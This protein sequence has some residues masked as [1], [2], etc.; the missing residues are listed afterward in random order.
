MRVHPTLAAAPILI[1]ALGAGCASSGPVHAP[2][3]ESAPAVSPRLAQLGRTMTGAF[4]SSA[5]AAADPEHFKDV[6]LVMT[7]IWPERT[8]GLWLYVEQALATDLANPYRQRVYHV[9]ERADGT[10]VSGVSTLAGDP[11]RF[12]DGSG[13]PF[14]FAAV[15]PAALASR[16]GCDVILRESGGVYAGKTDDSGCSSDLRGA[17]YATSEVRI[18]PGEIV[19]WDRGFDA[20]GKQVWGATKGG[21]VFK[22]VSARAAK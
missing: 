8:D 2:I 19:S 14:N 22:R 13:R 10:L 11:L 21:Y 17:A 4:S 20:A 18:A 15:T 6:R 16:D 12:T 7:R 9:T 1:A 5:Q 3:S